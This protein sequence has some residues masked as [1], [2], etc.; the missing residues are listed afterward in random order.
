[1]LRKNIPLILMLVAGAVACIIT[2]FNNFTIL[3]KMLWTLV[4]LVVFYGLGCILKAALDSFDKQNQIAN[5]EK[6]EV[7]EKDSDETDN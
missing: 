4:V 7:I 5:G 1:M 6:G 3:Q 2:F